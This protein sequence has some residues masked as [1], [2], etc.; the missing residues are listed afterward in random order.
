MRSTF[1]GKRALKMLTNVGRI[2]AS[3]WTCFPLLSLGT[4]CNRNCSCLEGWNVWRK[5]TNM[6]FWAICTLVG[7][8]LFARAV[9]SAATVY[10]AANLPTQQFGTLN[11]STG[12]YTLIGPLP[13]GSNGL[14]FGPG[15]KLFNL[16]VGNTVVTID[17]ATASTSVIGSTGTGPSIVLG[18]GGNSSSLFALGF[19]NKGTGTAD[20]YLINASTGAASILGQSFQIDPNGPIISFVMSSGSPTLYAV[21]QYYATP[22]N[23][24]STLFAIDPTTGQATMI[25]PTGI[26]G[27]LGLVMADGVLYGITQDAYSNQ[28]VPGI[29]TINTSTGAATFVTSVQG[30][31]D[32]IYGLAPIDVPNVVGQTQAA[33][34]T[35]I[36]TAGLVVG[37]VTNAAS[38][39]VP[40]G[41]V[42]S[43][44]PVA[45]TMVDPGSAVNLVVSSGPPQVAVPNVVGQTQAA[46]TT[47]ITGAG[48]VVGTVTTAA[49][50]T[51]PSGSVISESPVA[52][53]MVNSGSAVNLVVSSATFQVRYA[54]NLNIGDSFVDI[55]NTGASGGNLCANVYTFD[56]SEELISCCTCSVTPNGL[57]SLSVL[58]SLIANPLTPATPTA[59]VI[60]LIATSGT[61]NAATV[62]QNNL[63]PGMLAW[64]T[65]LHAQPSGYGVT[66]SPFLLATLSTAELAHIT[67]TC[68]F[69]QSNGS[70]FGI[71]KGCA[72]GGLGAANSVQ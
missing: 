63:A 65:S 5:C 50:N 47:A 25:G 3:R 52:G 55:T 60:K 34:S 35:A 48:L 24:P 72:A 61:C 57:Q 66:E 45:G 71:C 39:T 12:A 27:V 23:L 17:P 8:S 36:T 49:S 14:I 56:P 53:T 51:V 11:L 58:K 10:V 26:N 69:I 33:A 31:I 43:E 9:C 15:G 30:G 7:L 37:T 41:S 70:G 68:G 4:G 64:G 46:A 59:A 40:S 22:S 28:M 19:V 20:S 13:G 29:Y 1:M 54:P 67:S 32:A 2:S 16:N 42:I 44:S 21:V 18:L 62:T 38:N 6:R